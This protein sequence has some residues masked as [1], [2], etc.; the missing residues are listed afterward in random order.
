MKKEKLGKK[1]G[2][3]FYDWPEEEGKLD[4]DKSEKA[5]LFNPMLSM[6]IMMS[7]FI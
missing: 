3:G 2:E 7:H 1:T 5:G 6:A 4:I